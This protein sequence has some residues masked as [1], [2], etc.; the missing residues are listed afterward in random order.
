MSAGEALGYSSSGIGEGTRRG[1]G[2]AE[3]GARTKGTVRLSLWL[4]SGLVTAYIADVR[5]RLE[6]RVEELPFKLDA[7]FHSIAH[8]SGR[9]PIS[10]PIS[11]Y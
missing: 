7:R 2:S 5:L 8:F 3:T 10:S 9:S 4:R 6:Q 1:A 11:D